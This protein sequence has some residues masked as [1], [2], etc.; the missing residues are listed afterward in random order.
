MDDTA[1]NALVVG[2][3]TS[4]RAAT[5]LLAALGYHVRGYDARASLDISLLPKAQFLGEKD[6][7]PQAL[8]GVSLVVL[9]PGVAPLPVRAQCAQYAPSATITGE[10]DLALSHVPPNV[11]RVLITGTNGKSTVTALTGALL[12][13]A[14]H[15]VFVGGNLGEPLSRVVAQCLAG[16][17]AWPHTLVLECSSYQ[18]E[19]LQN[20]RVD[21]AALLNV[22]PDHLDRYPSMDTYAATKAR[23]FRGVSASGLAL[24]DAND[25]FTKALVPGV[26]AHVVRV[27]APPVWLQERDELVLVHHNDPPFPASALRIAG[28]H[29][30]KNALFA[31]ALARHMGASVDDCH[32]ALAAFAGLPHRMAFVCEQQGV[33][34]YNDSKATNIASAVASLQ[35]LRTPFVAIIGGRAKGDDPVPLLALLRDR[36][37]AV[38]GLGEAGP[39]WTHALHNAIP[40]A[41]A[42]NMDEA[43]AH[44]RSFAERGDAVVLAPGGSSFDL[45]ANFEARGEAFV[46]AL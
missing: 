2:M 46:R 26:D 6:V 5:E 31:L 12:E 23:I 20:H 22:T 18:L 45:Y 25:A 38:V 39:S 36:A 27:G 13:Q 43:V 29:N 24:F 9:S 14:G 10:L 28:G 34:Y 41:N 40:T 30:A 4:G 1:K 37:R 16:T 3:G 35:G 19:T 15:D 7:P 32:R 44:A 11:H 8:A 33:R 42:R 21:A 17:R